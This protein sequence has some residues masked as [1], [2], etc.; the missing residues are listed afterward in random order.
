MGEVQSQPKA[1]EE[2]D[3]LGAAPPEKKPQKKTQPPAKADF[4]PPNTSK[5]GVLGE[6]R[7]V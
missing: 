3:L 1:R 2:N 4:P 5:E 6:I 7:W